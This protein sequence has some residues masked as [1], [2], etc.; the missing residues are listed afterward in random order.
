MHLPQPEVQSVT[1]WVKAKRLR[2]KV[3]DMCNSAK[4]EHIKTNLRDNKH[5]PKK[6]WD[7]LLHVWGTGKDKKKDDPIYFSI[8]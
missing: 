1:D 6:F 7:Q 2:N 8:H 5:N 3:L 4:N